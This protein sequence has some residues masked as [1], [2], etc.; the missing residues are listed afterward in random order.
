MKSSWDLKLENNPARRC[1]A[2]S[3]QTGQPCRKFAVAGSTVC[4]KHGGAAPQ[5]KRA[6]RARLENAADRMA[7]ELLKMATD[8]NVADS[9][10]LA[11]LRDVLDRAGL[12]AKTAVEVEV[13]FKPWEHIM[14]AVTLESGSRA[15]YRRS[16]G[17]DE[18]LSAL[19]DL[20]PPRNLAADPDAPIDAEIVTDDNDT[21]IPNE[22]HQGDVDDSGHPMTRDEREHSSAAGTAPGIGAFGG[23]LG[24]LGPTSSGLLSLEDAVAAEAEMRRHVAQQ[25]R[26]LPA[27]PRQA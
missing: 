1:T 4:R 2:H 6:A 23:S 24:P 20:D 18:P 12:G 16:I 22:R 19:A 11:A 21:L 27:P 7:K 8:D 10:K 25:R 3:S 15:D 5:V 13:E 9:V 14:E 26:A 17:I